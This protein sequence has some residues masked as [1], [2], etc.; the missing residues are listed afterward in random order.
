MNR[1]EKSSDKHDTVYIYIYIYLSLSLS[2]SPSQEIMTLYQASPIISKLVKIVS[3]GILKHHLWLL[4]MVPETQRC[5]WCSISTLFT[6]RSN[7]FEYNIYGRQRKHQKTTSAPGPSKRHAHTP[8]YTWSPSAP[9]AKWSASG[10]CQSPRPG[11]Q[12]FTNEGPQRHPSTSKALLGFVWSVFL[13][14]ELN[15]T[16]MYSWGTCYKMS[17]KDSNLQNYWQ[18]HTC[19]TDVDVRM[20]D[21]FGFPDS[22]VHQSVST[23][24][25]MRRWKH[26]IGTT[27]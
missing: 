10:C 25:Y 13:A 20:D 26:I 2:P 1:L 19:T 24:V 3:L 11:R 17:M 23:H 18:E 14:F 22:R 7:T 5:E 21:C 9:K 16:R 15:L 6:T 12:S 4:E 8:Q 27:E